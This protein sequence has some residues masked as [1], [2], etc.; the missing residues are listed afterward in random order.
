MT[1][2]VIILNRMY[3]GDYLD[4]NLGHEAINLIKPDNN[5]KYCIYVNDLGDVNENFYKGNKKVSCILLTRKVAIKGISNTVEI[6]AKA[7][8][9]ELIAA[10]EMSKVKAGK[11]DIKLRKYHG[12]NLKAVENISYSGAYLKDI[13]SNN[14]WNERAIYATYLAEKI[15]QP[16]QSIYLIQE[17]TKNIDDVEK[18]LKQMGGISFRIKEYPSATSLKTYIDEKINNASYKI[19][20]KIIDDK[21]NMYWLEGLKPYDLKNIEFREYNTIDIIKKTEDE[22]IYSN[23]LTYIFKSKPDICCKF[24]NK[25][26]GVNLSENFEIIRESEGNIDILI[27]DND[28]TLIVIENKIK[29]DINGGRHD[30]NGKL[31]TN[32]LSK[33]IHYINGEIWNDENKTYV[34][35][36]K[37]KDKYSKYECKKFILLSPK[38]NKFDINLINKNIENF[39]NEQNNIVTDK[40]QNLFYSD[41]YDFYYDNK[42]EMEF[43]PH[44]KEFMCAI[45]RHKFDT[46]NIKEQKMFE[47]FAERIE[48]LNKNKSTT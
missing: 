47:R 23:L 6:I 10:N 32:Q 28:N 15:K 17:D 24:F 9:L 40:Y 34:V 48:E 2:D 14:K 22:I 20:R 7:E 45:Y 3:V 11:K 18:F 41:I 8:N 1:Q 35:N 25:Y 13:Y 36:Q 43:V 39:E 31:V 46:Y 27:K 19:L 30:I 33:Y 38:Y 37:L 5:E 4:E 29:S 42:N 21:N 12:I 44:F 16:K 26:L